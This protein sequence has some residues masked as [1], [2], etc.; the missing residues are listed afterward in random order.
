M[1]SDALL[2]T[3]AVAVG[4]AILAAPYYG[5]IRDTAALAAE[6]LRKH[7]AFLGRLIA[8]G[9]ILAAAWGKIPM[10]TLPAV[11]EDQLVIEVDTPTPEL[12]RLVE[13]V[14]TAL[15][16]ASMRDRA[17][18]AE[19]WLKSGIVVAADNVHATPILPDVRSLR[20]FQVVALDVAWRRIGGIGSGRYPGLRDGT[21][22]AF[23][24]VLGLDDVPIDATMRGRYVALVRALAWAAR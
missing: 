17:I 22:A 11:P 12:Q 23:A 5:Q 15:S 8:V 2:R 9:L 13:P 19:V 6:A 1:N 18:W 20:A 24:E 10:P 21:E 7:L 4:V 16:S 14:K 3:A